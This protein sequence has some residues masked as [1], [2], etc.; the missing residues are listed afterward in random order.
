ME[1]GDVVAAA[2]LAAVSTV[3]VA[4]WTIRVALAA[5]GR[6]LAASALA[7]VEALL[8]V[9]AF[10][11]VMDALDDPVRLLGYASGVAAGTFV[12]LT[13]ETR[14][15]ERRMTAGRAAGHGPERA[16][17]AATTPGRQVRR[18]ARSARR[19]SPPR[20]RGHG[21]RPSPRRTPAR[22]A[23]VHGVR[24]RGP[25][26]LPRDLPAAKRSLTS[27]AR[28][29]ASSDSRCSVDDSSRCRPL[30]AESEQG[31][32]DEHTEANG[33]VSR[34]FPRA[35]REPTMARMVCGPGS[36][37]SRSVGPRPARPLPAARP[38][39]TAPARYGSLSRP[40]AAGRCS[41]WPSPPR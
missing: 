21:R 33:R 24:R 35:S 19:R 8:F 40:A 3:S 37:A 36:P 38:A 29:S 32:A 23:V 15:E 6:R 20:T 26:R 9:V 18:R 2:G 34:S 12:G 27:T 16:R 17:A 25:G 39:P 28:S 10:G 22:L 13:L 1:P 4:L 31:R 30:R 5:H 14:A 11:R 41:R 7:S